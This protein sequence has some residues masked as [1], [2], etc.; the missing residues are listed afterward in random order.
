MNVGN[1]SWEFFNFHLNSNESQVTADQDVLDLDSLKHSV[2]DGPTFEKQR[3][4]LAAAELQMA[5]A[6]DKPTGEHVPEEVPP[7]GNI[8][9]EQQTEMDSSI[10]TTAVDD[11]NSDTTSTN[12]NVERT[13]GAQPKVINMEISVIFDIVNE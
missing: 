6:S 3:E 9:K 1:I 13:H 2:D 4:K 10:R 7:Y 11:A 8:D 12:A 5:V